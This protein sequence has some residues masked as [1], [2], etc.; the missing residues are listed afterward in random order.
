[1]YQVQ[2]QLPFQVIIICI[3]AYA[4][5][6]DTQVILAKLS[7]QLYEALYIVPIYNTLFTVL[8]PVQASFIGSI[9]PL[10]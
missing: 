6:G 5:K 4:L 1:V 10:L 9:L 3:D 2:V 7:I 8:N